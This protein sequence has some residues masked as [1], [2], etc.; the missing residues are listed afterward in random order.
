[1]LVI[2]FLITGK[3]FKI[4]CHV[5]QER[6]QR[7]SILIAD[8]AKIGN[9]FIYKIGVKFVDPEVKPKL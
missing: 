7:Q 8:S 1:M 5:R 9:N 6:I 2:F 3:Y 4:R